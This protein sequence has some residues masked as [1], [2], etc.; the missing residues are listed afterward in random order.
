MKYKVICQAKYNLKE[1]LQYAYLS[2]SSFKNGDIIEINNCNLR[3]YSTKTGR[4][5]DY[6]GNDEQD[7]GIRDFY[8]LVEKE[9]EVDTAKAYLVLQNDS[10]IKVGDKVKVLRKAKS[11]EMGWSQTWDREMDL[12][13][14]KEYIVKNVNSFG[15][16]I[17]GLYFPFFV[18]EKRENVI[19]FKVMDKLKVEHNCLITENVLT[20]GCTSFDQNSVD[21]II[22][23]WN[24]R[25]E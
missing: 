6:L 13:V 12:C 22:E 10:G 16:S 5:Y 8:Y 17:N 15:I 3:T 4:M 21:M 20:M 18:L 23:K 25:N 14:G 2:S 1:S 19:H 9:K 11:Y 7:I 24:G